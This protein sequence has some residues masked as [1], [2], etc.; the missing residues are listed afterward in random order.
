MPNRIC[1]NMIVKNESKV[2]KRCLQSA[3]PF[4]DCVHI[5]DTGSTDDTV[6]EIVR[7][8]SGREIPFQIHKAEFRDFATTRNEALRSCR[9]SDLDFQYI[10]FLDADMQLV[11]DG[12]GPMLRSLNA[13]SYS[14]K[15]K[16]NGFSYWRPQFV[17]RDVLCSYV[18]ST[19]EFLHIE[20]IEP[21]DRIQYIYIQDHF[22]GA[23]KEIRFRRNIELLLKDLVQ[24]PANSRAVFYLG[25]SHYDLHEWEQAA[26][27]FD[28]RIDMQGWE[29]ER[30]Y[31][32]YALARCHREL[33]NF[34][35]FTEVSWCAYNMRPWRAE[36]LYHL[37]RWYCDHKMWET[38]FAI[39]QTA[40]DVSYPSTDWI[41]IEEW[42]YEWGIKELLSVAGNYC[43]GKRK[44]IGYTACKDL[45]ANCKE[46]SIRKTAQANQREY[47]KNGQ[48]QI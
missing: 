32:A 41:W 1:L 25:N 48:V 46:P 9:A 6:L 3:L 27:Y 45:A 40:S 36:P 17:R 4:I 21:A 30:W 5:T 28:K 24:D 39:A 35:R 37:S 43:T 38:G 47:E 20:D 8:C 33:D 22:D 7:F 13:P 34:A 14:M 10:L 31:A 23:D 11:P 2:I 16:G 12:F 18:G 29:E 44:W 26:A 42:I 19:H 15:I